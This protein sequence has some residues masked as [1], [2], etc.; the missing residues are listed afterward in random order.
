MDTEPLSW[1][2]CGAQEDKASPATKGE[3]DGGRGG[4]RKGRREG[5][6]G[7]SK[8]SQQ[9]MHLPSCSTVTCV[10]MYIACVPGVHRGHRVSEPLGLELQ[11]TSHRVGA[12]DRAESFVRT[13]SALN[14]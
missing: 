7:E 10:S 5:R 13:A 1:E 14:Y 11:V 3:E 2:D 6:K 4:G 9:H 8:E 12:Q